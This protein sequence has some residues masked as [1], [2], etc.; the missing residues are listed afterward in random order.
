[1]RNPNTSKLVL[2]SAL[3]LGA[4]VDIG[5]EEPAENTNQQVT[6]RTPQC[7]PARLAEILEPVSANSLNVH[8]DC[9]LTLPS[10][11]TVVT[12]TLILQG[13]DASNIDIDCKGGKLSN[14]QKATFAKDDLRNFALFIVPKKIAESA[15]GGVY[16]RPQGIR[17]K[18]CTIEGRTMAQSPSGLVESSKLDAQH[19]ARIQRKAVTNL[20]FENVK[21]VAR[22][23]VALYLGNGSTNVSVLRSRFTGSSGDAP[24]VYLDAEGEHHLFEGN[25]FEGRISAKRETV[26]IDGSANNVFRNNVFYGTYNVLNFYRNCG[27]GGVVHVL[28]PVGNV[29]E[30]NQFVAEAAPDLTSDAGSI[31]GNTPALQMLAI[32]GSRNG[33]TR[34]GNYGYCGDDKGV[35]WGT[36]VDDRDHADNNKFINNKIVRPNAGFALGASAD[37]SG[38]VVVKGGDANARGNIVSGNTFADSISTAVKCGTLDPGQSTTRVAYLSTQPAQGT[39]C[40]SETQTGTC[41]PDGA[42]KWTGSFGESQCTDTQK[43]YLAATGTTNRPCMFEHRSRTCSGGSCTAPSGSFTLN[44]C[45]NAAG[46][47]DV[48][49]VYLHQLLRTAPIDHM[50]SRSAS[51]GAPAY[52]ATGL[53]FRVLTRAVPGYAALYRCRAGGDHFVSRSANCEGQAIEG[54]LGYVATTANAVMSRALSR[55]I[56]ASG[57]HKITLETQCGTSGGQSYQREGALGFVLP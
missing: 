57:D 15:D 22:G 20:T 25:I 8:L 21:F 36:S 47:A 32:F 51:E 4:C 30:N 41:Q 37:T 14:V 46:A 29:I 54:V 28:S 19:T 34:L 33:R 40:K 9:S 42:M 24:G 55:C 44:Q 2:A 35:G 18:N 6:A 5:D 53:A 48:E 52:S 39:A 13:A 43:R 11:S 3:C 1:M 56:G 26:A 10:A 17:V 27:E 45:T 49:V 50:L 7:S 38:I 16:T 12:K 31:A 23:D